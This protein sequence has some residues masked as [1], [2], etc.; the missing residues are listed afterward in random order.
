MIL[1]GENNP[2]QMP[3]VTGRDSQYIV[4]ALLASGVKPVSISFDRNRLTFYFKSIDIHDIEESG[5]Y[6]EL[7]LKYKDLHSASEEWRARFTQAKSM[8]RDKRR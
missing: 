3:G 2:T 5:A 8:K 6:G 4:T 1:F 7:K